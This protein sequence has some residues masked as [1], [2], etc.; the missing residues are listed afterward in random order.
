MKQNGVFCKPGPYSFYFDLNI[1]FRTRKVNGTLEKQAPGPLW[2]LELNI[3]LTPQD[4]HS[5]TKIQQIPPKRGFL[6]ES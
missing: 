4:T 1:W 2:S 3:A 6:K 5:D